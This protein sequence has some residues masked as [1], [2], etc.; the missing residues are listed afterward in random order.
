MPLILNSGPSVEPISVAEAKA[1]CRVDNAA[2]DLLIA[3]LVLAARTHVERSLGVALI[4]QSWSLYLDRWPD[5]PWLDL[6]LRPVISLEAVRLYSPSDTFMTLPPELFL[7][8][9]A[10]AYPR[11]ARREA[12]AWPL[13]GRCVNGIE[14]AFT[15]GFGATAEDVPMPIRLAIKM[16]VAHW[17]EM[18]EPVLAGEAG[19]ALPLSVASLIAPYREVRL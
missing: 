16:L 8:D 2:E 5:G 12:V 7:I 11:L 14:I 10:G 6:P 15:A 9:G 1:H 18:R 13:P 19:N 3:G 4:E 17:Y